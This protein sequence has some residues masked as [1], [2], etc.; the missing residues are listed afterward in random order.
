MSDK[1]ELKTDFV[2][3]AIEPFYTG[4]DVSIS[5]DGTFLATTF[6]SEVIVTNFKTG[7]RVARIRGVCV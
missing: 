4:G 7:E 6:D 2:P 5:S 1:K 3:S